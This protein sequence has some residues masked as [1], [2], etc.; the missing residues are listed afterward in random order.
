[1]SNQNAQVVDTNNVK[2]EKGMN[3]LKG[4]RIAG[5]EAPVFI[6]I[7][8]I[9][10]AAIYMDL[11]PKDLASGFAVTMFLG[12][13]LSWIGDRI[14]VFNTFGGGPLLCILIPALFIY[15]GILPDSVAQVADN[16]Y[17]EIGFAEIIVTGLIVGSLLSM[18]RSILV[19]S[20]VRFLIPL[21]AGVACALGVGG[22]VGHLIGFGFA[23]TIFFVVGPIMGGGMAAGAVPMSEIY[24]ASGNG[25]QG[26]I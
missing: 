23:E 10:F 8:I 18:D 2:A 5:I 7:A 25:I 16:F 14:P 19:K 12:G 15:W 11:L 17:N 6:G 22:L 20:G 13:L 9:M 26:V 4:L 24:A 3:F 1:M 21:L